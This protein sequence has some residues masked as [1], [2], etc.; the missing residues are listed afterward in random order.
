[1]LNWPKALGLLYNRLGILS[2]LL[3][4]LNPLYRPRNART[5][6][7][8]QLISFLN[9]VN[10]RQFPSKNGYK[11]LQG[12]MPPHSR[13]ARLYP[14]FLYSPRYTSHHWMGNF[15]KGNGGGGTSFSS[16]LSKAIRLACPYAEYIKKKERSTQ[17]A[18]DGSIYLHMKNERE[19]G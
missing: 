1:M 6:I 5:Q 15:Q 3:P 11:T 12:I 16:S 2:F 14:P 13:S 10:I 7:S 4:C 19:D 18:R 9:M 8:E 17:L